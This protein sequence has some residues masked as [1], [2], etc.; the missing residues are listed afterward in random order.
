MK[1]W[2]YKITNNI[3]GK[4]YIGQSVSPAR[5]FNSH[6]SGTLNSAIHNAIKKYGEE[7]FSF[8]II[9]GP[10]QN[11]NEREI[12]WIKF[13]DSYN[14]GYNRTIG[15]EYSIGGVKFEEGIIN[16]I[17]LCLLNTDLDYKSISEIYGVSE[18]YISAINRGVT[19][20]SPGLTYP[21]KEHDNSNKS[22]D[23]VRRIVDELMNTT[24]SVEQMAR[25]FGVDSLTI[26]RINLGYRRRCP[27]DVE[28]PI[29]DKG[30]RIS[31]KMLSN[32]IADLLDN[33]LMFSEIEHKYHLSKSVINRINQGKE[34]KQDNLD[35]PI[36][37]SS[38]R[39]HK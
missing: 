3:N 13:Y 5:R 31:R 9:E 12:Y 38:K 16:G 24:K 21:I 30:K 11:Y 17:K 28:Y 39:V 26:Y 4:I 10:I 19:R 23:L 33:K 1:K 27:A 29:R 20:V 22:K 2:I 15:G 35:Y 6:I 37:P 34:Y 8:D 14:T 25:D 36:R 18:G 32:I 7:N